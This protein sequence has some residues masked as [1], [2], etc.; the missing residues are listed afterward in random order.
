MKKLSPRRSPP[1]LAAAL[2]LAADLT[3]RA[4]ET[5]PPGRPDERDVGAVLALQG[6]LSENDFGPGK[7][8]GKLGEFTSKA[9]VLWN[10]AHGHAIDNWQPIAKAIAGRAPLIQYTIGEAEAARLTPDLPANPA[11]QGGRSYLGYRRLSEMVAERYHTDERFLARANPGLILGTLKIGDTLNVPNVPPFRIEDL[12]KSRLLPKREDLAARFAVVEV[13]Y[14]FI[15]IYEAIEAEGETAEAGEKPSRLIAAFPTTP[16][17]DRFIHR[18]NWKIVN[19]QVFPGFRYDRSMLDHGVRSNNAVQL[20]AGPNSPVGILW[21]GLN[22]SGIGLH[23]TST[24]E[25]I[26]R[27]RSAGCYRLANWDAARLPEF[28]TLDTPVIVR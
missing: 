16:G 12:G 18:G 23:G 7:V 11:R 28:L 27:A 8:D 13:D 24:P 15:L 3:T 1:L 17:E 20:P 14:R 10:T 19:M 25:T 2:L 26:G 5:P 4:E 6:F 9:V 21:A 22:R